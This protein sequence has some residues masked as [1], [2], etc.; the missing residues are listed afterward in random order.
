MDSLLEGIRVLDL[1][2]E[3]GLLCGRML[4]DMGADVIKVEKPGGD[5]ARHIGPFYHDIPY[6][7]KSLYWFAYNLNKKGITLNIKTSDGQAIL[8]DLQLHTNILL[9][10]VFPTLLYFEGFYNL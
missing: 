5:N 2:D 7:E 10:V 8:D 9:W 1:T 4:A 3:K 6:P